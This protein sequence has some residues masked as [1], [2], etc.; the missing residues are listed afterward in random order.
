MYRDGENCFIQQ[1]FSPDGNFRSQL[2]SRVT[3]SDDGN[4]VSEWNT[5][6][7]AIARFLG[8]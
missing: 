3:V 8:A 2:A 6:V 7:S 4:C 1:A 5:D